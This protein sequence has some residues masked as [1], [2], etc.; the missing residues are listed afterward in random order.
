[1]PFTSEENKNKEVVEEMGEELTRLE[2]GLKEKLDAMNKEQLKAFLGQVTL[3][4]MENQR[5]KKDDQ[6][7][8]EKK[9]AAKDAAKRYKDVSDANS[10]KADYVKYLL[11]GMGV[12]GEASVTEN[13]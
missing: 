6:D 2:E 12:V 4:E 10:T 1:M 5:L 7:L 11:E 9:K 3:N 8:T 13:E